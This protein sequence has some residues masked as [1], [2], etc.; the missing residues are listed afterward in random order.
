M[1]KTTWLLLGL[2]IVTVG[3]LPAPTPT[4]V[5]TL[6][7]MITTGNVARVIPSLTLK[8]HT[9]SVSSVKWSP[10]GATIASG[11]HDK[12]V[13]L[14]DAKTGD[15]IRKLEVGKPVLSVAWSPNGATLATVSG[16]K[17]VTIWN[18]STGERLLTTAEGHEE[19]RC[20][21]W[22]PDGTMLASGSF[23]MVY[24]WDA[25]TGKQLLRLIPNVS[26]G[27]ISRWMLDVAWS[28][29]ST[30]VAAGVLDDSVFVWSVKSG[31]VVMW[32]WGATGGP[33]SG[34]RSVAF[35]QDDKLL[36]AA[37][38]GKLRVLDTA[39]GKPLRELT[40][41]FQFVWSAAW[42]PNGTL[43]ASTSAS[44]TTLWDAGTGN[45]LRTL[46]EHSKDVNSVAWSPNGT[47]F[48]TG[49]EDSTVILWKLG[50]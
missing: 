11:A 15:V 7:P 41:S 16:E 38:Y 5:S 17:T 26:G 19:M 43:L 3:C 50:Q 9:D 48:V 25:K 12:R 10:D 37:A 44:G 1:K 33:F 20:V 28:S 2:L 24:V 46:K 31:D 30:R 14:W 40:D 8:G 13:I 6:I 47:M 27:I 22:S 29:D 4:P 45:L 23:N 18:T 42:S 34:M 35:S 39:T 49:S 21:A 32:Y 36:A